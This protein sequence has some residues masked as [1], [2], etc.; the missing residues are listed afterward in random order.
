M[1]LIFLSIFI[2]NL[3][4]ANIQENANIQE[5]IKST[6][7]VANDDNLNKDL[8]SQSTK[9]DDIKKS[10]ISDFFNTA[11]VSTDTYGAF[12]VGYE[13]LHKS[14]NNA[15]D[16][17]QVIYFELDRGFLFVDDIILFGFSLDGT[18]GGFYSININ[19]KL[20]A[21]IFD[22]R[23]IPSVGI[24]YGLLNHQIGDKQY[25]LHGASATISIF[26][27]VTSGFGLEAGYRVGLY[28]FKTTQRSNI[29]VSN[30]GAFMVNFKFIDF[31]I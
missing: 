28:P 18:A 4:Y 7:I 1:R 16:M 11:K 9:Q 14:Y 2:L 27:D 24:G 31:S 12:M 30:I 13:I 22:G 20:G 23:M 17:K 3:I 29:K 6:S 25:N 15:R 5:L 19:T 10:N 8:E 21:R 26:V